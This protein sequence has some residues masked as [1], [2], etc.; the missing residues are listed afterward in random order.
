MTHTKLIRSPALV[1]QSIFDKTPKFRWGLI[2]RQGRFWCNVRGTYIEIAEMDA[3]YA[4]N[5]Y[6]F[7]LRNHAERVF[8]A[9]LGIATRILSE[10]PN[11]ALHA[12]EDILGPECLSDLGPAGDTPAEWFSLSPLGR[13]L[14][15]QAREQGYD[16]PTPGIG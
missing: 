6:R 4:M 13:A 14:L 8:V 12:I 15:H 3:N 7:F 5:A 16:G 11:D 2:A 10:I 9:E 1:V